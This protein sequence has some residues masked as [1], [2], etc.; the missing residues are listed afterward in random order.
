MKLTDKLN[1]LIEGVLNM[2]YIVNGTPKI[3]ICPFCKSHTNSSDLKDFVHHESCLHILAKELN[4]SNYW[5]PIS[6]AIIVQLEKDPDKVI[7]NKM[8]QKQ[9]IE[10][11]NN[12]SEIANEYIN[13]ILNISINL[14]NNQKT[15]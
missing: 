12:K 9:M 3:I 1:R 6:E 4:N 7:Y 14:I 5:M 8:T 13:R 2:S 15:T 10:E 11:I